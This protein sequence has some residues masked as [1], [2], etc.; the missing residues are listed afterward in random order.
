MRMRGPAAVD[1][2][3]RVPLGA[4]LRGAGQGGVRGLGGGLPGPVTRVP[5]GAVTVVSVS[6]VM[7]SAP[8]RVLP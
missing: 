1:Q 7:V 5:P 8:G 2:L 4:V 6:L 3:G